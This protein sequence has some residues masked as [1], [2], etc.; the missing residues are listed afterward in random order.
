ME[1]ASEKSEL[2]QNPEVKTIIFGRPIFLCCLLAYSVPDERLYLQFSLWYW[3]LT[4]QEDKKIMF[5][6]SSK[7]A[8][9]LME[10]TLPAMFFFTLTILLSYL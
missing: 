8:L 6:L 4:R 9:V 2:F 1:T 7:N 3:V 10:S 5:K